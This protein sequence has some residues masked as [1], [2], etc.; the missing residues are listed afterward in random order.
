MLLHFL[1]TCFFWSLQNNQGA[2]TSK[3]RDMNP[4]IPVAWLIGVAGPMF[5]TPCPSSIILGQTRSGETESDSVSVCFVS[6]ERLV[7]TRITFPK[8]QPEALVEDP[9]A[10]SRRVP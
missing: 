8:R 2:G 5:E 10:L 1:C 4:F 9:G 6:S 3:R 7:P